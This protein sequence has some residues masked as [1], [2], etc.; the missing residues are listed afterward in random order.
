MKSFISALAF[1]GAASAHCT[2]WGVSVNNKDLGYG[3]SQ[4]GYIDTP[5]NN[6][7]VT[8]VT[9][10][11]MECNVANIKASKSISINPG[12]E[13]AVQ[14]FH[15]G[16]GAGD[17]IID[18]SHKGPINVYMSKAGSSMS[19]TK[20]AE[21]GWDG[22]SWAVTKLRDGAYNGKKGQHTFKMP[23]VAAGDYIIRPEIIAL[24]EGNRP[25]G[26]QFYMGCIHVKVGGS[27]SGSLPAGVSIPGYVTA[28]NPGVL[29]NIYGS[30]Q[31]YP[32]PGPKLWS[33]AG[34]ATAADAAPAPAPAAGAPAASPSPATG[35]PSTEAPSSEAPAAE[36]PEECTDDTAEPA[37]EPAAPAP[38]APAASAPAAAPATGGAEAQKWH[39][40]GGQGYTG[41]TACVSGTSCVKQND[42]YHQCM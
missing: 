28:T 39:Q 12:D 2:I 6:S 11:A 13:V 3:N 4:G 31:N 17:Q 41:A 18:G 20:I 36:E 35:A 16:P 1:A 37:D 5:P 32:N 19:W 27:A 38:A 21:D 34:T 15:N 29:F 22:K 25:S 33:G 42:Y 26:A 9:S 7:P 10:K 23:N 8:D 40:C 30:F 14:W 24:H